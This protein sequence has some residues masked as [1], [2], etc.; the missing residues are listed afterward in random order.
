VSSTP[1]LRSKFAGVNTTVKDTNLPPEILRVC[2]NFRLPDNRPVRRPG[3]GEVTNS[4]IRGDQLTKHTASVIQHEQKDSLLTKTKRMKTPLSY[5]LLKWAYDYQPKTTLNWTVEFLLTPGDY[6]AMVDSVDTYR[7]RSANNYGGQQQYLRGQRGVFVYDQSIISNEHTFRALAWGAS[8]PVATYNVV[9][10]NTHI[11][12]VFVLSA[13]AISF[14]RNKLYA[15]STLIDNTN[16]YWP[17]DYIISATWPNGQ[18]TPGKDYHIAVVY[19]ASTR[20]VELFIDGVQSGNF[21]VPA[22][23]FFAGEADAI[24]GRTEAIQR[25]IVL[26]N[27]CMVRGGYSSTCKVRTTGGADNVFHG[28]YTLPHFYINDNSATTELAPWVHSPPRGTGICELRIWG[29]ARTFSQ[30]AA[31][32]RTYIDSATSDLLGYWKLHDGGPVC[33]NSKAND[34]RRVTLHHA[35]PGYVADSGLLNG[36]GIDISDNQCLRLEYSEFDQKFVRDS[37]K[38]LTQCLGYDATQLHQAHQDFVVQMQ[39]RTPFNRQQEINRRS[40]A[41]TYLD[42]SGNTRDS[43]GLG[44]YVLK[45]GTAPTPNSVFDYQGIGTVHHRA[46]DSTLWSIEGQIEYPA[47]QSNNAPERTRTALARGLLTPEGKVAFEYF[48]AADVAGSKP[49][50]YRIVS[51]DNL[52]ADTVYTLTFERKTIYA[53]STGAPPPEAGKAL[54]KAVQLSIYINNNPTPTVT[55]TLPTTLYGSPLKSLCPTDVIIG[56]SYFNDATDKSM[57]DPGAG[58][59]FVISQRFMSPYQDQPGFFTLGFFRMWTTAVEFRDYVKYWN[60]SVTSTGEFGASLLYNIEVEDK[61]RHTLPNKSVY[62][63]VFEFDFK[64]WGEVEPN[65]VIGSRTAYPGSYSFQDCLG[66]SPKPSSFITEQDSKCNGLAIYAS[67]LEQQRGLLAVFGNSLLYSKTGFGLASLLFPGK[68][69]LNEFENGAF[70]RGV[71]IGDRTILTS[72]GGKPKIFDG[73]ILSDLGFPN[74]RGGACY[75]S[76]TG[77]GSLQTN[78]WYGVRI[79]YVS[80]RDAIQDVSPVFAVYTGASQ[81]ITI[82]NIPQHPDARVS[83][84]YICRTLAQSSKSLALSAASY[85]CGTTSLENEYLD[86]YV[87]SS[88]V[89]ILTTAPIDVITTPAPHGKYAAS[90]GD[91]LYISGN[92]LVPDAVYYSFDGNPNRFDILSRVFVVQEG[93]GE[94][95]VG[96]IPLFGALYIFKQSSIWRAVDVGDGNHQKEKIADVGAVSDRAITVVT[97][98][99]TGRTAIVFWSAYGPY[100]FD[101]INV[102]YIGYAIEGE[103]PYNWLDTST[104]FVANDVHR[105]EVIFFYQAT[106]RESYGKHDRAVV[107]NYRNSSWVHDTGVIASAALNVDETLF[108]GGWNGKLYQWATKDED[109]LPTTGL[110]ASFNLPLVVSGWDPDTGILSFIFGNEV[111]AEDVDTTIAENAFRGL[112][113]SIVTKD[114]KNWITAP[115]KSSTSTTL[116]IDLSYYAETPLPFNPAVDDFLYIGIPPAVLETG[117]DTVA[118]QLTALDKQIESIVCWLKGVFYWNFAKDW[119]NTY[120]KEWGTVNDLEGKRQKLSLLVGACEVG[121]LFLMSCSLK[122]AVNQIAYLVSPNNLGHRKQ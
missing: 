33:E 12:D 82:S 62:S 116:S 100:M 112:W 52:A 34:R 48:S 55:Y 70:W 46:Y 86:S 118:P 95:I 30:I 57:R 22:N 107:F 4:P 26:L 6:E 47:N 61:G 68:G 41:G 103:N 8:A 60:S 66:Y 106:G 104:L 13:L 94:K 83:G 80:E 122:A 87:I 58:S 76:S 24:N 39:I 59:G 35:Y 90:L 9:G 23:H 2:E 50:E 89:D 51:A 110:P 36:L 85:P 114:A 91:K 40:G 28:N 98:P 31:N 119:S 121:K 74:W 105:R 99:E 120:R 88:D 3:F 96:I 7:Q 111:D 44:T 42:A 38:A 25:D 71:S 18:Y 102:Q 63:E 29:V 54:P 20:K 15:G 109:G 84:I 115:I 1:I 21:T 5:G 65:D 27:E 77:G 117:W 101:G 93:N 108:L 64:G 92:D 69:L 78:K 14:D 75:I 32:A 10:T 19:T 43:M 113:A 16:V 17:F 49:R 45:D 73:K 11:R 37:H 53:I 72:A 67:T 56:A 81:S 97:I 79:V